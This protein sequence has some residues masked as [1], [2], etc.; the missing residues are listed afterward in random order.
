MAY[1]FLVLGTDTHALIDTGCGPKA[2]RRVQ[3][4][5]G[6]DMV[7]NSHCHPDH[8]S[9]NHLLAGKELLVP[10]ERV[11]EVGTI[12]RLARRLMGPDRGLMDSWAY[13]ARQDLG[14]AD[15]EPTGTFGNGETLEFGGISLRAI[16][17]PGHLDDHY[18]FIEPERNILLSFDIDLT[19]FGPFYG[20]PEADIALFKDSL[21][22]IMD[23][24]PQ[25][26]ASSHRL[27]VR[28]DIQKELGSFAA[29]FSRNEERIAAAMTVPR[30]LE[31][32]CAQKPIYGK[33]I[34]GL[35]PLYSFF[36][37]HMVQK[38]LECMEREGK[39]RVGEGT[40]LLNPSP[41]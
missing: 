29:K 24:S 12:P 8:V 2:I 9:G 17:T 34:P 10:R 36:E 14:M 39:V 15:Y 40:F 41:G 27:P 35:E 19:A 3:A 5:Y 33:H 38:H 28:E 7:I 37:R 31:K 20:N 18:C 26:V 32:I 25:V 21:R 22:V 30:S 11:E 23:M 4:E 13:F 1:S 6:V 16:H